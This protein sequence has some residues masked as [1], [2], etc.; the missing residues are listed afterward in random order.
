VSDG[1][2]RSIPAIANAI[3]TLPFSISSRLSTYERGVPCETARCAAS[4][5]SSRWNC[6]AARSFFGISAL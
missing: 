4:F 6:F 3:S 1:L 5:A 2:E